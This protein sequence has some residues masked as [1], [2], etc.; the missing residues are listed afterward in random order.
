M[1]R[2]GGG[3]ATP[4]MKTRQ[5][6]ICISARATTPRARKKS[7][8]RTSDALKVPGPAFGRWSWLASPWP[9]AAPSGSSGR[10]PR[11]RARDWLLPLRSA[12][13]LRARRRLPV[14]PPLDG[15]DAIFRDL[16]KALSTHPLFALWLGQK[17]LIRTL[18]ALVSNVAEGESPR[19]HLAF[20]APHSGFAVIE[21]RSG[22]LL[23]DPAGYARYDAVGDAAESLDPE[24]CARAYRVL[25]PLFE[26]AYR[27]L[28]HPEGGFAEGPARRSRQAPRG[29]DSR[30]RDSPRA[31]R[32]DGRALRAL[33]RAS[34]GLE[35]PAK[36]P[37]AD[38]APKRRP[39]PGEAPRALPRP[40]VSPASPRPP[41]WPRRL[42]PS[43]FPKSERQEA[44][45]RA[46]CSSGRADRSP[47]P[48]RVLAK[49]PAARAP[50][51]PRVSRSPDAGRARGSRLAIPTSTRGS[52]WSEG[53]KGPGKSSGDRRRRRGYAG[54]RAATGR[55]SWKAPTATCPPWPI[56]WT[57]SAS[58]RVGGWTTSW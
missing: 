44:K 33:R 21:R 30:R 23:L 34:R 52:S 56:C 11:P 1:P 28:G 57:P 5:I 4:W 25:E 48:A 3:F 45:G 37:S 54:C 47:V 17:E 50:G 13:P 27:E 12:P 18:A 35:H 55:S 40:W 2:F 15:S 41:P 19:A 43:P 38:G 9:S 8:C 14:L 29:P 7:C 16:T 42:T 6:S 36:A 26:S 39:H 51:L 22:R 58:C 53:G 20:L 46:D 32:E 10:D 31:G 49:A 24:H